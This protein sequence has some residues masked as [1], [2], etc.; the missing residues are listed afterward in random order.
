MCDGKGGERR[1]R[2]TIGAIGL[3]SWISERLLSAWGVSCTS[4][5]CHGKTERVVRITTH[6]HQRHSSLLFLQQRVRTLVGGRVWEQ[7]LPSCPIA[8]SS[9]LI[10]LNYL[11]PLT[12]S[13]VGQKRGASESAFCVAAAVLAVIVDHPKKKTTTTPLRSIQPHVPR[14]PGARVMKPTNKKKK[15][16][17]AERER[18]DGGRCR[19]AGGTR[20]PFPLPEPVS[21]T[22]SKKRGEGGGGGETPSHGSRI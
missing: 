6:V 21:W 10:D 9:V 4:K 18:E 5:R 7:T 16:S 20:R 17:L 14:R 2:E 13:Q 3:R 15:R 19:H 12:R 22:R 11:R 1:L 8:M